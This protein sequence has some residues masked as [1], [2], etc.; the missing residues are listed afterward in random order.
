[1]PLVHAVVWLDHHSAH[2]LQF[3]AEQVQAH[4]LQ[5]HV[6]PTPQHGSDVR[7]EHEFFS[8]ICDTLAGIP[9]VLI[10]GG[11]TAQSDFRH[12][13]DKHRP[14]V[15]PQIVGWETVDHPSEGQLVALARKF[16]VRH[17]RM[18]GSPTAG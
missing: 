12:Y 8:E 10:T 16:F 5:A 4:K 9:Q 11:H 15:A 2:V 6:H 13:V 14:A 1:M 17:E 3:D 18:A 7:S